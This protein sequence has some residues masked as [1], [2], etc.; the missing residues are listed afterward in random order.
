MIKNILIRY[1][2]SLHS[3]IHFYNRQRNLLMHHGLLGSSKDF[4]A[5]ATSLHFSKYVNFYLIDARNHGN[6][7]FSKATVLILELTLYQTWR[8]MFTNTYANMIC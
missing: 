3:T 1:T 5:L 2:V 4:A 6:Y 7:G 8:K